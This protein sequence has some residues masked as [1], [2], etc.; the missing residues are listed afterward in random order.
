MIGKN[1]NFLEIEHKFV[2]D[3]SKPRD[4]ILELLGALPSQKKTQI[5][6]VDQYF[7]TP[8]LPKRVFRHRLDEE[9][10]QLT[11]KSLE[12]SP[13]V[14]KE[15]NLNLG[16]DFGDQGNAI[17]AFIEQL[18]PEFESFKINKQVWVFYQKDAEIVYYEARAAE[19]SVRCLEIEALNAPTIETGLATISRYEKVL[20]FE[21]DQASN[22]TLLELLA[23]PNLVEQ[24]S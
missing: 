3:Q 24:F 21:A 23:P 4:Q 22:K 17:Q 8:L 19:L 5:N 7:L 2:L 13:E 6:V 10:Q 20:G 11:L 1:T 12:D 9:I 14:R 18:V 15:I 16:L